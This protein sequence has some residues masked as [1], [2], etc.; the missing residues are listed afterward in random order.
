MGPLP[1]FLLFPPDGC[2]TAPAAPG[3]A[4]PRPAESFSSARRT[5]AGWRWGVLFAV[6]GYTAA[7]A[8]SRGQSLSAWLPWLFAQPG[9]FLLRQAH[10]I[11]AVERPQ[12]QNTGSSYRRSVR[13]IEEHKATARGAVCTSNQALCLLQGSVFE[14]CQRIPSRGPATAAG[15]PCERGLS[16][17]YSVATPATSPPALPPP[18]A[19][20][21]RPSSPFSSGP[22]P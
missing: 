7:A 2:G 9:H 11:T 4:A 8:L 22:A 10:H 1:C 14:T 12:I 13:K 17:R 19:C 3:H 16:G 18:R 5:G 6:V 15:F 21:P 20:R